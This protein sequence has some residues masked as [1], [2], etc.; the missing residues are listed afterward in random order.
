MPDSHPWLHLQLQDQ[1]KRKIVEMYDEVD[2]LKNEVD[3]KKL[4][5]VIQNLNKHDNIN[6]I[7]KKSTDIAKWNNEKQIYE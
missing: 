5:N 3:I 4:I 7:F 1:E 6:F 2:I